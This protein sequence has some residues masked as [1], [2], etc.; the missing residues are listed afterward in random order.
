MLL[1]S[2]LNEFEMVSFVA[3][4]TD[5]TFVFTFHILSCSLVRSLYFRIFLTVFLITVL[6]PEIA[7]SVNLQVPLSL[8]RIMIPGFNC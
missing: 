2:F 7:T 8:S 3:G 5:I 4:N 6:S 1:R